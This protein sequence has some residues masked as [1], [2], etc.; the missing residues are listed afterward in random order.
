LSHAG[1]VGDKHLQAY[2]DEYAF[3][4]NRRETNGVGE[5]YVAEG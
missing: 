2:L 1:A 4:H 3:R 5:E